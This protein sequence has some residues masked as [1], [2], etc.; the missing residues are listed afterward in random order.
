MRDKSHFKILI[1]IH[2]GNE[3]VPIVSP[4][5]NRQA[6]CQKSFHQMSVAEQIIDEGDSQR[7][8]GSIP[9]EFK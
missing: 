9:Q 1:K 2:I 7:E 6:D 4:T 5:L 8:D 3:I